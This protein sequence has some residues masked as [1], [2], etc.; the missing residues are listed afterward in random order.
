MPGFTILEGDHA[1]IVKG[2]VYKQV[3]VARRNGHL[4][5][6]IAGGF[7]QLYHDGST[8][9]PKLRCEELAVSIPVAMTKLGRLIE[10]GT[11]GDNERALPANTAAKLGIENA[12]RLGSS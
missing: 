6:S 1:I 10:P 2:G 9:M 5:C 7:V 3:P 12:P 8:S 11:Q 4:F